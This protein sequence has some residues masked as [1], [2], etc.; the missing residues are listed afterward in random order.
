MKKVLVILMVLAMCGIANAALIHRYSFSETS[1]TTFD[2]SIGTVD[3]TLVKTGS[4]ATLD[5]TKVILPGSTDP[6][7]SDYISV[8]AS[9]LPIGATTTM[10]LELWTEKYSDSNTW[11]R[12]W[13]FGNYAG[14]ES[15]MVFASWQQG[16]TPNTDRI[17]SQSAMGG[18]TQ[19]DTM[20]YALNTQYHIVFTFDNSVSGTTVVRWYKDGAFVSSATTGGN[21]SSI[22]V[23]YLRLG[24]SAHTGG[25]GTINGAYNEFRIYNN[26][27]SASDVLASFN[28][29]PDPVTAIAEPSSLALIG[30][31]LLTLVRRRK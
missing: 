15:Q 30:L 22:N 14:G 26:V 31:G 29:G 4:S 23:D 7:G 24:R 16:S 19:N 17:A 10:T 11:A 27:L 1:G 20:N 25:E 28:A 5:G 6:T 21:I 8:P 13:Q 18:F 2:D 12:M 3:A 9:A